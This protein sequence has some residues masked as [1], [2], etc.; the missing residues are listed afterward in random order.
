M[1]DNDWV[2]DSI[3]GHSRKTSIDSKGIDEGFDFEANPPYHG[4]QIHQSQGK[5]G[6]PTSLT[7]RP[8]IT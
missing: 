7:R 8:S 3:G 5:K 2:L 6:L 1:V 4:L